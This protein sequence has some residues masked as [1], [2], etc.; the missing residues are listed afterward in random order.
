MAVETITAG[1]ATAGRGSSA[2]RM[3]VCV[4]PPLAPVTAT[5]FGST[6]GSSSSQSN[7]RIEL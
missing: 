2:Q 4:P 6:S 1:K 3:N 7:A 5:R